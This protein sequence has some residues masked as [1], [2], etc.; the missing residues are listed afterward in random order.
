MVVPIV[1]GMV[2]EVVLVVP[3]AIGIVAAVKSLFHYLDFGKSILA[4]FFLSGLG[5]YYRSVSTISPLSIRPLL[6]SVKLLPL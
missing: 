5:K 1:I 6:R 3:I 4:D 2:V